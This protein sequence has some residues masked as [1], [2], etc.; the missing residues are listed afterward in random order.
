M[1]RVSA[2][3]GSTSTKDKNVPITKIDILYDAEIRD[4]G[5]CEKL[6]LLCT[7]RVFQKERSYLYVREN[8]LETNDA[9]ACMCC[10]DWICENTNVL[11]FDRP[12]FKPSPHYPGCPCFGYTDPKLDVK[13]TGC[14]CCMQRIVCCEELVVMPYEMLPCP[15]CCCSN[16]TPQPGLCNCWLNCKGVCAPAGLE[17]VPKVTR[18]FRPQPKDP[19]ALLTA[20]GQA[21]GMKVS[22]KPGQEKM[23]NPKVAPLQ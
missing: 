15:C 13:Q 2:H 10:P 17:G 12:P 5:M 3:P 21:T 6:A 1:A 22:E 19:W 8:S 4:V 23:E 18:G 14:W 7:C 16:R 9:T 20:F 11:Y